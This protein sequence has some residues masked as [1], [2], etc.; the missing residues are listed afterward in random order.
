MGFRLFVA[1]DYPLFLQGLQSCIDEDGRF[2]L[3]GTAGD[4]QA[5]ITACL[6]L[7]PDIA[8]VGYNLP[9][10]RGTALLQRLQTESPGTRF[11]ALAGIVDPTTVHEAVSVGVRGY[12]AKQESGSFI[13]DALARVGAGNTAFSAAAESCLVEAVRSRG[14]LNDSLPSPREA[15]ILEMMA[16]GATTREVGARLYVSEATVKTYLRRLYEKLDV[17]D[18]AAAVAVAMRRGWLT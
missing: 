16:H 11:V 7:Q 14:E 9:G 15:E 8:L 3:V 18:R 10:L 4:A 5:A 13:L 12:V 17:S 1:D 6:R 2:E